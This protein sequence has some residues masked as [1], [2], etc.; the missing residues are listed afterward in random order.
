MA[1]R[2][3]LFSLISLK[4]DGDIKVR[5]VY[6]INFG[7]PEKFLVGI[8]PN[9]K[10]GTLSLKKCK[11]TNFHFGNEKFILYLKGTEFGL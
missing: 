8:A 7:P 3:V 9:I 1:F 10:V 6:P 2:Y 5:I 11:V 4:N